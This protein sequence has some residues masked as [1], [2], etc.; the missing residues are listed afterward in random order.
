MQDAVR[1]VL[2]VDADPATVEY[3]RTALAGMDVEAVAT[4]TAG[5]ERVVGSAFEAALLDP[6]LGED[7]DDALALLHRLRTVA[8]DTVVVMWSGQPTVEFAV[9]AMRAGALDVLK[10]A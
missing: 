5:L 9:R 2:I 4:R 10:K 6:A 1:H 7:E 8:P 3:G